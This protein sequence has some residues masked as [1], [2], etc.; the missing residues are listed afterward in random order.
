MLGIVSDV[1]REMRCDNLLACA[2]LSDASY[3]GTAETIHEAYRI[4]GVKLVED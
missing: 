4:S 3:P 1:A 2:H